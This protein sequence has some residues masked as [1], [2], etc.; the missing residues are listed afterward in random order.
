[1]EYG[2][3]EAGEHEGGIDGEAL[4]GDAGEAAHAPE[5][6]GLEAVLGGVELKEG[7]EAAGDVGY[8]D[9]GDEEHD[10]AFEE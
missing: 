8:H 2:E 9:A 7:D 5:G 6:V 10:G 4:D 3:D 1:M